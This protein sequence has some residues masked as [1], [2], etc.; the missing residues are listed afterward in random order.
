MYN[1]SK[2]VTNFLWVS[3]SMESFHSLVNKNVINQKHY[4]SGKMNQYKHDLLEQKYDE[5]MNARREEIE[6]KQIQKENLSSHFFEV[7][8]ETTFDLLLQALEMHNENA[9]LESLST[10]SSAIINFMPK[11]PFYQYFIKN[12]FPQIFKN[13]LENPPTELIF[14][15]TLWTLSQV[16][17]VCVRYSE[18]DILNEFQK[19]NIFDFLLSLRNRINNELLPYYLN[20]MSYF[21]LLDSKTR[22]R[23]LE[24]LLFLEKD[25]YFDDFENDELIRQAS[26][27]VFRS[28]LSFPIP[29]YTS[30]N[31]NYKRWI[32]TFLLENDLNLENE[33]KYYFLGSILNL[34]S[35]PS[36]IN[37]LFNFHFEGYINRFDYHH[38]ND[39]LI[40][41][42]LLKIQIK[43]TNVSQEKMEFNYIV[44]MEIGC[45][46]FYSCIH[47]AFKLFRNGIEFRPNDRPFSNTLITQKFL[48]SLNSGIYEIKY[49]FI[50][51]I[52]SILNFCCDEDIIRLVPFLIPCIC[53]FLVISDE[54]KIIGKILTEILM[55]FQK[56]DN[57]G[58]TDEY[59]RLFE[60]HDCF[61]FLLNLIHNTNETCYGADIY[62]MIDEI[63]HFSKSSKNVMNE[64]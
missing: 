12:N 28:T 50:K 60:E 36:F 3:P 21:C 8:L 18:L 43:M 16:Y 55:I 51:C 52:Y 33:S 56:G 17:L 49:E 19:I 2:L 38:T 1:H 15:N 6:E 9:V 39:E 34:C 10:I 62:R 13:I 63:E 46:K 53:Q 48:E 31:F 29:N 40:I 26:F 59:R 44:L 11:K 4:T 37:E 27:V 32:V 42:T 61:E 23:V 64:D 20:L 14:Q 7:E 30:I 47:N 54:E 5:N 24:N 35:E 41:N 45:S 25:I 22:D 58:L 57:Y